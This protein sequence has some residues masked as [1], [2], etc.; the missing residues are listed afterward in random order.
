MATYR[1]TGW[2]VEQIHI[3]K[4]H[5]GSQYIGLRDGLVPAHGVANDLKAGLLGHAL[6]IEGND[7]IVFYDQ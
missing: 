2:T 4:R 5:I 3:H 6:R 1:E 7:N